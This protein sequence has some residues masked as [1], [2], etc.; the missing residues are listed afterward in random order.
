M[1]QSVAW[2]GVGK[3]VLEGWWWKGGS[4]RVVLEGWCWKG[5]LEEGC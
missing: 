2:S 3:V 1:T 4:G 5:G